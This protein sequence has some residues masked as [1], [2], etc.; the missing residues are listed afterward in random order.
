MALFIG[1]SAGQDSP[2]QWLGPADGSTGASESGNDR[3]AVSAC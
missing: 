2:R 3:E 1:K